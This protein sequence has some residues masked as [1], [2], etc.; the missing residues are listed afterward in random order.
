ML[1][2][3]RVGLPGELVKL[4]LKFW[5]GVLKTHSAHETYLEMILNS[6]EQTETLNLLKV[7]M[8]GILI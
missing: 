4:R 7:L 3:G 2:D 1:E 8:Y 6:T 5:F